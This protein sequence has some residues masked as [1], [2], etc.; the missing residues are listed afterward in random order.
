MRLLS[1]NIQHGGG[2]RL[3]RIAD[4]IVSHR[5]DAVALTEFRTAPGVALIE[6]FKDRGYWYAEST[7]P[8]AG[9]NGV[10]V[11]SRTPIVRKPSSFVPAENLVQWL[12][13]ELPE[14]GFGLGVM[15]ILCSMP[16][17]K[18]RVPGE[19]KIRFWNAVL[20][21]AE[22]RLHE[23]FLFVGDW[24]TG[25][26]R[27]DEKGKTFVCAD[28]FGKLSAMGWTDLW[29]RHNPGNTEFTWYS[30]F[31]GGARANGFRLDHAFAT[32]SLLTRVGACRYSHAERDAA[33][34]DHSLMVVDLD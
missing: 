24:N 25:A 3:A 26:H 10:A 19:A 34:S 4:A 13:V 23:P 17:S 11:I 16:G 32:P 28:H 7:N 30:K 14:H 27:V 22:A 9:D 12:D 21:A 33:A 15:H 31:K 8:A 2:K 20:E 6:A 29:R 1:W 5:P 18:D